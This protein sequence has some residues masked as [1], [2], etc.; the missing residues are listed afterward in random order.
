MT[1]KRI[2]L[3]IAALLA[4]GLPAAVAG[5]AAWNAVPRET[6]QWRDGDFCSD[7]GAIYWSFCGAFALAF[8]IALWI[9]RKHDRGT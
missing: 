4:L 2:V 1:A 7:Y 8:L 9:I 5:S 6:C 3:T